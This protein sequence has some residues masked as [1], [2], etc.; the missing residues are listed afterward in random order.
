MM[1]QRGWRIPVIISLA[2]LVLHFGLIAGAVSQYSSTVKA[3]EIANKVQAGQPVDYDNVIIADYLDLSGLQ[4]EVIVPFSIKNSTFSDATNLDGAV[5]RETV[6]LSGS[7]FRGNVSFGKTRLLSE[8]NFSGIK[9]EGETDFR[10]AEFQKN[11][12]FFRSTFLN[13]TSFANSLFS[14]DVNFANTFFNDTG[15]ENARFEGDAIFIGSNFSGSAAFDFAR[16]FGLASFWNV[17]FQKD[18][19]FTNTW[20]DGPAI[21]KSTNFLGN[22]SFAAARFA[23]EVI[24]RSSN[25]G[26]NATFGLAE[27]SG[28]S[29]FAD[30]DF[31]GLASFIVTR[32]SD[33]A[34]FVG[35]IFEK[36]LIL[37]GARIYSMQLDNASFSK[38]SK[39]NLKD[40]DFARFVVHWNEIKDHLQFNGAAYLALVKN[41]KNL[42]WFDD[43]DSAYYEYRKISMSQRSMS[44]EKLIDVIAWLSSGFGVRVSYVAFWCIFTIIFFGL[45]FWAGNGMKRFEIIGLEIPGGVDIEDQHVSLIDAM[46]F[47]TAMFT[48]SQ[49]PVNTYPIGFYRHLAMIEGI[50]GWF[51][52]GLFVVVLSSLLIR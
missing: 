25:F 19:S 11:A 28:F 49:A 42:E 6:D 30:V 14:K 12:N 44:W 17:I 21:F 16:F 3:E 1:A 52:L 2:I 7:T 23:R 8:S 50:L 5:F 37:E 9:M 41:Y 39:I 45:V 35:A 36:D 18:L 48:T 33:N 34:H 15:F 47:S 22:T 38:D 10:G 43:A 13:E 31:R 51:F 4:N 46:Y 29:D 40:A 20:F 27:L 24:F 26:G 32:F